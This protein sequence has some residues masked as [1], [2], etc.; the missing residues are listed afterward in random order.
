MKDMAYWRSKHPIVRQTYNGRP[1]P[2]GAR[3]EIDVRHFVWDRDVR[4]ADVI[5]TAPTTGVS[6][7]V[8]ALECQRW[9]CNNITYARDTTI[10]AS[11]YWLFPGETFEMRHGDCEDGACLMASLL[12][13]CLPPAER[14]RVRVSAGLVAAGQN[15]ELGGHAYCT[16]C[17]P[18]DNEWVILDWCYHADPSV[19]VPYKPR[20]RDVALYKDVWFSF[21]SEYA[22]AHKTLELGGRLAGK[23]GIGR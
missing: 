21:N 3:Y 9:V 13:I 23:A 1:L 8:L 10:G 12:T 19:I 6:L 5:L 15:A 4:L 11:E 16:F 2:N 18:E 14:W 7:S 22:W 17:R 20:A